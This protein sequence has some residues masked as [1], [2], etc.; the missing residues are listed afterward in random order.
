MKT[1]HPTST[2]VA[3][4]DSAQK[5]KQSGIPEQIPQQIQQIPFY[6]SFCM[7]LYF[8]TSPIHTAPQKALFLGY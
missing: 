7:S 2:D 8:N 4:G 5:T 6:A 1:H 3:T